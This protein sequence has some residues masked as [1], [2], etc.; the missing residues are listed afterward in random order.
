MKE[1]NVKRGNSY[2]YVMK[3]KEM[4]HLSQGTF[5]PVYGEWHKLFLRALLYLLVLNPITDKQTL[6]PSSKS[7][8]SQPALAVPMG[9]CVNKLCLV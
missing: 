4:K 7:S 8:L 9:L 1:I 2:L 6:S 5:Q 3:V